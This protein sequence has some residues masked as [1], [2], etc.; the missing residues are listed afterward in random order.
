[1]RNPIYLDPQTQQMEF[2]PC[3]SK[4]CSVIKELTRAVASG[5]DVVVEYKAIS[6]FHLPLFT[7]EGHE[8]DQCLES[9]ERNFK[10]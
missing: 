8:K 4:L 3:A 9:G 5:T 10:I 2:S 6:T 7:L 1:M